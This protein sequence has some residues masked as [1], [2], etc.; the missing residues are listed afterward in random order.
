M[1]VIMVS[2][3]KRDHYKIPNK[4][5]DFLQQRSGLASEKSLRFLQEFQSCENGE[6]EDST[7][8]RAHLQGDDSIGFRG[9]LRGAE[10]FAQCEDSL[11]E[12]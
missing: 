5:R 1:I 10:L 8:G 12:P 11:C 6:G 9:S 4:L 3:K 7:S 2:W